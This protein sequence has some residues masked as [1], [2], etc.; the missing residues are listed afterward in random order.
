MLQI[1]RKTPAFAK[2]M[3]GRQNS[4]FKIKGR[5]G[6]TLMEMLV[7]VSLFGFIAVAA[8]GMFLSSLQSSTKSEAVKAVRH[9]GDYALS[10]MQGMILRSSSV[11]CPADHQIAVV[12]NQGYSTSFNCIEPS[13]GNPGK[14]ASSSPTLSSDLTTSGVSVSGCNFSCTGG[15][16]SPTKVSIRFTV[17]QY[18]TVILKSGEKASL[19]F[20][21]EVVSKNY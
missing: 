11:T 5:W 21:T 3:A 20:E 8:S 12:D 4:K 2:A 10:I 19:D 1:K 18:S 17:S 15:L 9:N 16:G 6:F 13:L 7:V 14:I